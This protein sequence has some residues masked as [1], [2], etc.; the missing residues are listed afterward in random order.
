MKFAQKGAVVHKSLLMFGGAGLAA[1]CLCAST[2]FASATIDQDTNILTFDVASGDE[3]YAQEIPST[4]AG[5]VKTGAGKIVLSVA[6][7]GFTGKTVLISDGVLEIQHKNALGSG[8]TVT[9]ANGAQYRMVYNATQNDCGGQNNDIVLQGGAGP[10]NNGALYGTGNG[11]NTASD[12]FWGNVTLEAD[13]TI[14][15]GSARGFGKDLDLGGK[16]LTIKGQMRLAGGGVGKTVT[17]KNPGKIRLA[18]STICI[19]GAPVFNAGGVFEA[20]GGGIQMWNVSVPVAWP[21]HLTDA[22]LTLNMGRGLV[23]GQSA[24]PNANVWAGNVEIASG[25]TLTLT[26]NDSY[27]TDYLSIAGNITGDGGVSIG[28]SNAEFRLS[29]TNTY[30]G[31]T[32]IGANRLRVY[33]DGNVSTNGPVKINGGVLEL[34]LENAGITSEYVAGLAAK[35]AQSQY[36]SGNGT[37]RFI[38]GAAQDVTLTSDFSPMHPSIAIHHEGDGSLTLSGNMP[39]DM[40]P[41]NKAGRLDFD[42]DWA[43]SVW[44]LLVNGGTMDV[45]GGSLT[46]P[47]YDGNRTYRIGSSNDVASARMRILNGGTLYFPTTSGDV[48]EAIKVDDLGTKPG[49]S[50]KSG[51]ECRA[52]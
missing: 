37:L 4:V 21:L 15:C 13:A 40:Q 25:R 34:H 16:T 41:V 52:A 14:G 1:A 31:G 19:Q 45:K 33:A 29:G 11:A 17:V 22:N 43:R 24:N 28:G 46:R 35:M 47:Y 23:G 8:N 20:A 6:S 30:S 42:G 51:T 5:I 36:S 9:V 39:S 10:D 18:S 49:C 48:S 50:A 2:A 7:T 38:T 12:Y 27:K 3:T 32:A 26:G 44:A